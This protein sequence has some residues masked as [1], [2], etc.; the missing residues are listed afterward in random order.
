[1]YLGTTVTPLPS[2]LPWKLAR[3]AITLD[4]F[5]HGRLIQGVGLGDAQD[6]HFGEVADMKQRAE[7]LDEGLDMLAGLMSGQPFSYEGT[8]Y[9]V[10]DVTF[11]PGPVQTPRIPIWLGGFWPRKAPA[12]RAARWDGFCPAKVPD[13]QGDGYIKPAD[14]REIESFIGKHRVSSAPFDLAAGGHSQGGDLGEACAHVES[15]REAGATWWIEFVLPGLGEEDE[16][17]ARIKQ[18]PPK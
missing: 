1:V 4:H 8:H 12:L 15:Y 13:E 7:M 16:A 10:N 6:L 18:G 3:E 14:I 11:R 2:R 5:S 17:L 9:Q